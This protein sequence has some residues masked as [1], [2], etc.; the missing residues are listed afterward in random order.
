VTGL[1]ARRRTAA[2]AAAVVLVLAACSS[3]G[4]DR[5]ATATTVTNDQGVVVSTDTASSPGAPATE[6]T[7]NGADTSGPSASSGGAPEEPSGV[8]GTVVPAID[9]RVGVGQLAP[10]VLRADRSSA[11]TVEVRAQDGVS[12]RQATLDHL[13]G[14]LRS[15]TGKAVSVDPGPAVPGGAR[16]WSADDLRAEADRDGTRPQGGGAVVL[17]ILVVHG[18]LGGDT[19]VLGVSVRGDTAAIF[20]DQVEASGSVLTGSASI[21]SAV[22]THEAGHLLGLVDLFL[23]T[24]RQD[25]DH[26]GHSTN[27]G[28]VMYWAVESSLVGQL[29][30]GGPPQDFD[31]DDLADL[32]TIRQGG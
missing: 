27:Q 25:P 5:A 17:R 21:E 2:V 30:G 9:G 32:A 10:D 12:L 1:Q 22:V 13:T 8:P 6:Q 26:P 24:G 7:S 16:E 14:V 19:G 29:L 11:V 23:H 15:V 28:S 4:K 31:A 3:D 20:V 18:S